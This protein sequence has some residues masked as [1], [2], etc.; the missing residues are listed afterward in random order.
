MSQA[1]LKV[2]A[3]AYE[4][5]ATLVGPAAE[6][7]PNP[8][9]NP[10][11]K[12]KPKPKV[13]A[14]KLGPEAVGLQAGE[15]ESQAGEPET[16]AGDVHVGAEV[17]AEAQAQASTQAQAKL[18]SAPTVLQFEKPNTVATFRCTGLWRK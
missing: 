12:P 15:P 5:Q 1:T 7:K 2:P 8:N 6:R 3:A 18:A 14:A 17:E 13:R 11:P 16:Q 10:K 4:S 9:P